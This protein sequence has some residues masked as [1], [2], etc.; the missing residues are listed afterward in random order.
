MNRITLRKSEDIT[1]QEAME[2][3]I[4]K[5]HVKNLTQ[6]SIESYEQ[7]CKKFINFIDED[8]CVSSVT[9]DTIDNFILQLQ[10]EVSEITVNTVLRSVRAY[11]Y[12][13]MDNGYCNR[14]KICLSKVDKPI[15]ETYTDS[16]LK[17]L[18]VKPN[19]NFTDFKI[20]AFINYL[21]G[22]GNRISTA[23]NVHICDLDFENNLI[24]L[25]KMKNR[26]Q[27][28]IPL[29]N[30]LAKC[31]QEY[32]LVRGG[33]PEDYL[34]CN[35]YGGKSCRRTYQEEV[36]KYNLLHDV[37]KSS[38][39]SFRHTFAKKWVMNHGDVFRLQK[40]LGHSSISVTKE[41]VDMFGTDLQI[42]FND[43]NP[44]DT[45]VQNKEYINLKERKAK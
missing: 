3:F 16:E 17:R 1:A 36:A 11:M 27:Q 29:S 20:W 22:T 4:R 40:I 14:F 25:R 41:Y 33:Q 12:F 34:F 45:L 24:T 23:L 5:C 35:N 7:K 19:T 2:L 28:I 44:L 21:L 31:L 30:T 9:S 6:N 26:K 32:L 39:H 10:K 38:C 43:Y 42:D 15:K 13:C 18:L 37:Q 8:T